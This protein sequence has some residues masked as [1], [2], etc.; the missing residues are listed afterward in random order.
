M[1]RN[2]TP[3]ILSEVPQL[4]IRNNLGIAVSPRAVNF[5]GS[6]AFEHAIVGNPCVI[7][8]AHCMRRLVLSS[9]ITPIRNAG[10]LLRAVRPRLLS[11]FLQ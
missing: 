2:G 7:T 11:D 5:T 4:R 3:T 8:N 6:Q 10:M 9:P 1:L